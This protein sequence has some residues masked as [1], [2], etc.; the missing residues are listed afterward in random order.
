LDLLCPK[1]IVDGQVLDVM[2]SSMDFKA[3]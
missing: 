2:I 3:L 1:D